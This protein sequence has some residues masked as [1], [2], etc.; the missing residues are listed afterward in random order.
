[1]LTKLTILTDA[2]Q[3]AKDQQ[4]A[5]IEKMKRENA[6]AAERLQ[7]AKARADELELQASDVIAHRVFLADY[8]V[9]SVASQ[10]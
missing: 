7:A 6:S 10:C 5:S 4:V 8:P 2:E 3:E 9:A 1:L